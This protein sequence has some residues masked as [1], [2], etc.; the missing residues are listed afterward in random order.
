MSTLFL[1]ED[2]RFDSDMSPAVDNKSSLSMANYRDEKKTVP[3]AGFIYIA[4]A[5]NK[6]NSADNIKN[7]TE[8]LADKAGDLC[9]IMKCGT[10]RIRPGTKLY[11][12]LDIAESSS[13]KNGRICLLEGTEIEWFCLEMKSQC[14][15][16]LFRNCSRSRNLN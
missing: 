8:N 13:K 11:F 15:V 1:C 9:G 14:I 4:N 12:C 5:T 3:A 10:N 6:N 16:T 7:I 2:D